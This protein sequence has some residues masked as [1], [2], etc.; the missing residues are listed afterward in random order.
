MHL[1]YIH[2]HKHTHKHMYMYIYTHTHMYICRLDSVFQK[3]RNVY[4]VHFRD[5]PQGGG[6]EVEDVREWMEGRREGRVVMQE[7]AAAAAAEEEEEEEE[8]KTREE[9]EKEEEEKEEEEKKEEEE[10]KVTDLEVTCGSCRQALKSPHIVGLFCPYSRSRL[11]L[12]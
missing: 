2:T 6:G 1:I 5:I 9:G 3:F 10:E 11:T 7:G 4:N 12:V 8:A